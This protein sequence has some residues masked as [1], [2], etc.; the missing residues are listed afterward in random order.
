M[1]R[2]WGRSLPSRPRDGSV[3]D[4]RFHAAITRVTTC[5]MPR[6]P[7][8]IDTASKPIGRPTKLTDHVKTRLIEAL[9]NGASHELAA[10]YA[11]IGVSTFYAWKKKAEEGDPDF[12]EFVEVIANSES[13]GAI[14][15]LKKIHAAIDDDWKAGAWIL[16]RRYPETYGRQRIEHTGKDGAP[17]EHV[18]KIEWTDDDDNSGHS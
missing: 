2:G 13:L 4:P 5:L 15:I 3:H 7:K 16:E 6:T 8:S 9:K 17:I 10:Q 18:F 14:E 1:P 11:G 12:Q